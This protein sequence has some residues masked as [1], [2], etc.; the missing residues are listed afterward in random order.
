[1]LAACS[2]ALFL[3]GLDA[4]IVNAGLPSAGRALGAG[5][6]GL[7]WVIAAYT[8]PLA[9]LLLPA[10]RLAD[11]AGRRAV[12]LAA[13]AVFAAG[14]WACSI[15][16]SL[17]WLL[18]ARAVQGAG[19]SGLAPSALGIITAVYPRPRE[20]ARAL[21]TWDACLGLG[22]ALGPPAGGVLVQSAGWRAVFW[23]N[24]P[25][26]L[27]AVAA[28]AL[29]AP[30]T[31]SPARRPAGL[32]GQL[33][34]LTGL[35]SLAAG[36]IEGP[37]LG[38]ASPW[39]GGAMVLAAASATGLAF[40]SRHRPPPGPRLLRPGPVLAALAG[41]VLASAAL[42]GWLFLLTLYLQD[43]RG[44]P[45]L[46]AGM[47][48]VPMPAAMTAG[49]AVAGR[50]VARRGPGAVFAVAGAGMTAAC[51][52]MCGLAPAGALPAAA[53]ACGLFGAGLGLASMAVTHGV[54][55]G[56]GLAGAA[57]LA[58]GLNSAGRQ[59]GATIGVAVSGSVLAAASA[60]GTG[61]AAGFTHAAAGSWQVLAACG[62][63]VAAL[64]LCRWSRP[65][66]T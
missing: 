20:R 61:P 63:G 9:A 8:V 44:L 65:A 22:M 6:S 28:V 49:S 32:A 47:V 18:A 1:M 38:W 3:T 12:L 19:A 30:E 5:T 62:A 26:A 17:G 54:M 58:S 35:G 42:A 23:V 50:V 46:R 59:I 53:A 31:R 39:T 66:R 45:A 16:P 10:G 43:V 40:L 29:L 4:T 24:V 33:L 48:I 14:S 7:Q 34:V 41:G 36:I 55:T 11:R 64:S 57:G 27:A 60:R 21:G 51:L 13:L 52:L 2:S 56:V 25:A 37:G 15:A